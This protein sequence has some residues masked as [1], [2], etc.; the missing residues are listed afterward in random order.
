LHPDANR[1]HI[2]FEFK[3]IEGAIA[4]LGEHMFER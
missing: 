3:A 2:R 1:H 4:E